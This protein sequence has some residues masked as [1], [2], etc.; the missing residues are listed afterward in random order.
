MGRTFHS[1]FGDKY[2]KPMMHSVAGSLIG[3]GEVLLLP[4]DVLKIK[5]QTNPDA[6]KGRGLLDLAKQGRELYR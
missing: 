4:L 1:L 6:L 2:A 3:V 5:A